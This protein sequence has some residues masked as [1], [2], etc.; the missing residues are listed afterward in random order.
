[1]SETKYV[2]EPD[3][4]FIIENYNQSKPFYSFFPGIAGE[5]GIPIWAFYVN[6]GQCIA[7]FGMQDK[8]GAIME[9]VPGDKAPW[10]TAWRGF[11]TIVKVQR[12]TGTVIYEPFRVENAERWKAQTQMIVSPAEL[13]IREVN[14]ELGLEV[15]VVFFTLPNQ[16]LGGLY[17]RTTITNHSAEPIKMQIVDGLPIIAPSGLNNAIAKNMGYTI[18]AWMDVE[19]V[20]GIPYYKLRYLPA[21][22]P[23]LFPV[24]SGNFYLGYTV[25]NGQVEKLQT[26]IDPAEI[27]GMG[28]DFTPT[29]F[30]SEGFQ[31]HSEQATD[32]HQP[33]AMGY[34][35]IELTAGESS[36]MYGLFGHAPSRE[37]LSAFLSTVGSN[38]FEASRTSNDGLIRGIRDYAFTSSGEKLFDLYMGQ[39]FM[40]N[41]VRGGVP[42]TLTG[43]GGEHPKVFWLYS[44]K[45]GDLERDY[46][47]FQ[48]SPSYY[49]QGNGNFRDINQNRRNDVWFNTDVRDS[50]LR[51]FWNLIQLDGF[52]PLVI[53]GLTYFFED[54]AVVEPLIREKLSLDAAEKVLAFIGES[55]TPGELLY[56]LEQDVK[57]SPAEIEAVFLPIIEMSREVESADVRE[58]Y[59]IDHWIYNLDLFDSFLSIYPDLWAEVCLKRKDYTFYDNWEVQA[60]T[61]RRYYLIDGI[62]RQARCVNDDPEKKK[63]IKAR[64]TNPH[65]VRT[66]K[67]QEEIYT[68]TLFGKML[69]LG[70][71]KLASFD[72]FVTGLEMDAGKPGW[73]DS[74]N[75][76]PGILGSSVCEVFALQRL[77][78][79]MAD[80]LR[81]APEE[82]VA[83]PVEFGDLL[84][85][86][87]G[88]LQAPPQTQDEM[89]EFWR[90]SHEIRDAYLGRTRLG[91]SGFEQLIPNEGILAFVNDAQTLIEQAIGRAVR[92]ES[93]VYHTYLYHKATQW[94]VLEESAARRRTESPIV[95]VW[96]EAFEECELPNFLEGQV[97]A[98]RVERDLEKAH[99]L[100][101][102]VRRSDL[103]DQ[104]LAMYKV[105]AELTG[106]PPEIGRSYIFPRG[107][108]ENESVFLHMEYKYLLEIL[109]SGLYDEF[110][111]EIPKLL[112]CYAK[113]EVYG[114]NPLENCSFIVTSGNPHPELHGNGFIARLSGSTAEMLHI[115]LMMSFGQR[116]F[117]LNS[118]GELQLGFAP[119]LTP[120]FF[121][122]EASQATVVWVSGVTKTYELSANVYAAKFLSKTLV[123]YHNPN[124][125]KTFGPDVARIVRIDLTGWDG[126][127]TSFD[128]AV[129]PS[130]WA[131]KVRKGLAERIDVE[132]V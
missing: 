19:S 71:N 92:P 86:M 32:N 54:V 76:L 90:A 20:E 12:P 26:I 104:K 27:F 109:R 81:T 83:L 127:R 23:E 3:G 38:H 105:C 123:V 96:P 45:H 129:I 47:E 126:S 50:A 21:D 13:E 61:D 88:L 31:Y 89:V 97:H 106:A 15:R 40:D 124:R 59:W 70:L 68:T 64:E 73:C 39:A 79:Q 60:P 78:R 67:G 7:G 107:W 116:P 62:V 52:N 16:P 35:Q 49:S 65:L 103:F 6:R 44:R 37:L 1:M 51:F 4:R 2:M 132:M 93:G 14:P 98:L 85:G 66:L 108:L 22:V 118:A 121:T 42:V 111:K 80:I 25:R 63:L 110:F 46:N 36:V 29:A 94:K 119:V 112:V 84:N 115:W 57:L 48:I 82:S 53:K 113:P 5:K 125:K 75:G 74:V 41:A 77:F 101:E 91:L 95:R 17:R 28:M 58:G 131:E 34:Q 33:S 24:V 117:R 120:E 43:E 102:A 114:R 30:A 11:R 130:E 99:G 100:Y 10:Y 56:L 69:S 55:F 122:K 87:Y 18:R 72:P 9:F 128:G 8:D